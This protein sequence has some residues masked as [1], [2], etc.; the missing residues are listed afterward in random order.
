M[1]RS[2]YTLPDFGRVQFAG[3]FVLKYMRDQELMCSIALVDEE[4]ALQEVFMWLLEQSYVQVDAD[5]YYQVTV[6][7]ADILNNFEKRYQTFLEEFD[8]FCAVDLQEG[9]F[10]FEEYGRFANQKEWQEFLSQERWEDLRVAVAEYKNLDPVE[11]V[12]MSFMQEEKFGPDES[13]WNYDRLLGKVWDDILAVVNTAIKVEDLGYE[14]D[15][16]LIPGEDVVK[17]IVEQGQALM[18]D[19]RL[20]GK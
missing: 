6:K 17:D 9:V 5:E 14:D 11:I 7:G 2:F 1:T 13:G 4:V 12:F 18:T 3:L 10:A 16:G 19:M 15:H 20:G 8:V